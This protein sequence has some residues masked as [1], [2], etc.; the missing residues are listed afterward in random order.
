MS[1]E[2]KLLLIKLAAL[3][4]LT[5]LAGFGLLRYFEYYEQIWK[6]NNRKKKWIATCILFFILACLGGF[7]Q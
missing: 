3:L 1:H 5:P 4:A 2:L 7:L 6:T